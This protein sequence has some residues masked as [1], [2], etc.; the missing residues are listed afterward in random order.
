[1]CAEA[2]WVRFVPHALPGRSRTCPASPAK[3]RRLRGAL[4]LI[5]R[6]IWVLATGTD[7]WHDPLWSLDRHAS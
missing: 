5:K 3:T 2:C 7:L 6:L 4:P 1:M